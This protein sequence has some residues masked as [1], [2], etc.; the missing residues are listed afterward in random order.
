MSVSATAHGRYLL[1]TSVF[2]ESMFWSAFVMSS[3]SFQA[4]LRLCLSFLIV[5]LAHAATPG[6]PQAT[7]EPRPIQVPVIDGAD[8]RFSSLSNEQPAVANER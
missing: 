8:I 5:S 6:V 1:G 2:P 4:L 7:V 3:T